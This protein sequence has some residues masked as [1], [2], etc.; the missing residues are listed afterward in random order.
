VPGAVG[1]HVASFEMVSLRDPGNNG[2]VR[3]LL[4]DGIAATLGPVSEPYLQAFPS[5]DEFFP[6][7]LTGKLTLAEVYWKTEPMSSWRMCL[8]G[9]P[10][11]TPFKVHPAMKVQDLPE[12]LQPIFNNSANAVSGHPAGPATRPTAARN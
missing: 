8:V 3:G 1:F 5:P 6:L 7:L 12:R 4:N 10:L 9:D 11:Y 2:W